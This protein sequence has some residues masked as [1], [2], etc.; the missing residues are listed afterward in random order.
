MDQ[1]GAPILCF[2]AHLFLIQLHTF[3]DALNKKPR[4]RERL[5]GYEHVWLDKLFPQS[6]TAA[7]L[8]RP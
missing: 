8:L 5:R 4:K 6:A 7:T 2:I 3:R 1:I